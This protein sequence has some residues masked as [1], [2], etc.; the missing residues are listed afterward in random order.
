MN[1][2]NFVLGLILIVFVDRLN[3]GFNY[4]KCLE[5]P[6]YQNFDAKQVDKHY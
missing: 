2:L 1:Y 4:G 6:V 3:A 5:S